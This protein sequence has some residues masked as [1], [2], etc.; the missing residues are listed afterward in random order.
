MLGTLGQRIRRALLFT[1]IAL[2][3]AACLLFLGDYVRLR[4]KMARNSQPY[5]SVQVQNYYAVKLKDGKTE[6]FFN[7]P[8]MQPCSNTL[9]PQMGYTPCWYLKRKANKGTNL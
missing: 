2:V 1:V 4:Y 5:G 6:Y 9:F 3:A 8:Q 7:P